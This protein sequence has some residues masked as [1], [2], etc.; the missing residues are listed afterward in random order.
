MV[1]D[2]RFDHKITFLLD[3]RIRKDILALQQDELFW[4]L[5]EQYFD[6]PEI[7]ERSSFDFLK[8][9]FLVFQALGIEDLTEE[10]IRGLLSEAQ[11]L[12][13]QLLRGERVQDLRQAALVALV[14]REWGIRSDWRDVLNSLSV[15]VAEAWETVLACLYAMKQSPQELFDAVVSLRLQCAAVWGIHLFVLYQMDAKV[16][17]NVIKTR[18]LVEQLMWLRQLVAKGHRGLAIELAAEIVDE[19]WMEWNALRQNA[20]FQNSMQWQHVAELCILAERPDLALEFFIRAGNLLK[21]QQAEMNLRQAGFWLEKRDRTQALEAVRDALQL[22]PELADGCELEL[23]FEEKTASSTEE[24]KRRFEHWQDCYRKWQQLP[25]LMLCVDWTSQ[26]KD[27]LTVLLQ[28]GLLVEAQACARVLLAQ[29]AL[30]SEVYE[31]VG[32]LFEQQGDL[33]DAIACQQAALAAEPSLATR[34]R[35]ADL[36]EAAGEW[37]AALAERE[38]VYQWSGVVDGQDAAALARCALRA[39]NAE[40]TWNVCQQWLEVRRDD[41]LANGLAG[42]A[43]ARLGKLDE[44][45]RCLELAT[46][47]MPKRVDFWLERAEV[48]KQQGATEQAADVLRFALSVLPDEI[49]LQLALGRVEWVAGQYTDALPVLKQ[50]WQ[51][52]DI[53]PELAIVLA[54]VQNHLGLKDEALQTIQQ[55]RCMYPRH[56]ELAARHAESLAFMG[57]M[58][59]ALAAFAVAVE[60]EDA[61]VEWL[62]SYVRCALVD[63]GQIEQTE[64]VLDALQRLLHEMPSDFEG[65]F[66]LGKL[67]LQQNELKNAYAVFSQ[68]VDDPALIGSPFAG[69]V[70]H[71]LG[72]TA[73]MLNLA[74]AAVMAFQEATQ[75][76]PKNQRLL[77]ELAEAYEVAGM[78]Q[79]AVQL[80]RQVCTDVD[81]VDDVEKAVWF[82]RLLLRVGDADGAVAVWERIAADIGSDIGLLLEMA[83]ALQ[84]ANRVQQA[85]EIVQR[86]CLDG[87]SPDL[88]RRMAALCYALGQTERAFDCLSRSFRQQSKPLGLQALELAYLCGAMKQWGEALPF[89]EIVLRQEIPMMDAWVWAADVLAIAGRWQAALKVLEQALAL[90][91]QN[92]V[93]EQI[94]ESDAGLA[95]QL[96]VFSDCL[97]V[98]RADVLFRL[99]R[100]TALQG[101]Y[102]KALEFALSGV[103]LRPE[104]MMLRYLAAELAAAQAQMQFAMRLVEPALEMEDTLPLEQ[105]G[106]AVACLTLC[107]ELALREGDV[108][109]AEQCLQKG[110]RYGNESARLLA[111]KSRLYARQGK[112]WMANDVF[113]LAIVLAKKN[114]ENKPLLGENWLS[115]RALLHD[116]SERTFFVW[117]GE[118]LLD[119]QRWKEAFQFLDK[120]TERCE[121]CAGVWLVYLIAAVRVEE[122]RW[123]YDNVHLDGRLPVV[124]IEVALKKLSGTNV[125]EVQKWIMRA[126]V[127][128]EPIGWLEEFSVK[129]AKD[130]EDAQAAFAAWLKS[131]N[132]QRA[133]EEVSAFTEDAWARLMVGFCQAMMGEVSGF[134]VVQEAARAL[135]FQPLVQGT[136]AGVAERC[137]E[138]SVA[139]DAIHKALQ[140]WPG[141]AEWYAW[142]AKLAKQLG[143]TEDVLSYWEQAIQLAPQSIEY[144]LAYAAVC[145]STGRLTLAIRILR[146]AVALNPDHFVVWFDLALTYQQNGDWSSALTCAERVCM[147]APDSVD[148]LILAG[149][150]SLQ[151][152]R[153]DDALRY[154]SDAIRYNPNSKQGLMLLVD[155]W[156]QRG[157][158]LEALNELEASGLYRQEEEL[159]RRR[160]SLVAIVQGKEAGFWAYR[161]VSLDFPESVSALIDVVR[162]L[163]DLGQLDEAMRTAQQ[164]LRLD[165]ARTDML[166]FLG[167]SFRQRGQLD[168]AVHF[169]SEA[170]LRAPQALEAQL[171]LGQTYQQQRQYGLALEAFER[172]MQIAPQDYRAFHLAGL[173][174]RDAKDYP[175][176]EAMLRRAVQL[177]PGEVGIRRQLAAVIALN[178]VQT[179]REVES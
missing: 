17:S 89:V 61:Q 75:L 171:E 49:A 88:L 53:D 131:K 36:L 34:R 31:Q 52:G 73:L 116:W 22:M 48:L 71:E 11:L 4:R 176:A 107:G 170:V 46:N 6:M 178:M 164:V 168:Q 151:M 15:N 27:W 80:A 102:R 148:G 100:L 16:L 161:Q 101:N 121:A 155:V 68:L 65:R 38:E 167:R 94:D 177:A 87:V 2:G 82:A 26:W 59:G 162:A 95:Q 157:Q 108:T 76:L 145:R 91:M 134:I 72:R 128:F 18:S 58:A 83:N 41:G 147:L 54:D 40:R 137:E 103:Q 30:S 113:D 20:V 104:N 19:H 79:E 81:D 64:Q 56:P 154:A 115:L 153:L 179:V 93:L 23:L 129:Q 175:G 57:D 172:A 136:L 114:G 174:K 127:V 77:R 1:A 122:T 133:A 146:E 97:G 45:L 37:H 159:G 149:Q 125:E 142:A 50:V 25:G 9:Q 74:D 44:A 152:G 51:S 24:L 120:A 123:L 69:E 10:R 63:G 35:L 66:L 96:F 14:L 126:K 7:V 138:W 105:Q 158:L 13:R 3:E 32:R 99:A 55:A 21:S 5:A 111:L 47:V 109:L 132:W 173:A 39:G 98:E 62:R 8:P 92:S 43:L 12:Y 110:R 112:F 141:Q 33:K 42:M 60:A 90:T 169:F 117:L 156:T 139:L 135:P 165:P 124:S 160:A 143:R 144:K 106:L 29:D 28:N 84:K 150:I 78:D 163:I 85:W 166:L 86:I 140:L 130:F 70:W 119:L 118:A 67:L